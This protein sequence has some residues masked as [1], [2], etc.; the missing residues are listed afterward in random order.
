MPERYNDAFWTQ[1]ERLV[2]QSDVVIDRPK[3][4]THPRFEEALYPLDYGYLAGTTSSDGAGIDV[5]RGDSGSNDVV[6][7]VCTVDLLKRDAEI[8]V[9]LGC[10]EEEMVQIVDF[11][12]EGRMGA[13]LIRRDGS[14]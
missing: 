5:W 9:L 14:A 6:G 8:K 4:S 3:D 1:L 10:T 13:Y 7:V 11:H 12:N 2:T